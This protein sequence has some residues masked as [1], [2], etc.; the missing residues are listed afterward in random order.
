M[1]LEMQ[2]TTDA[3]D[4]PAAADVTHWAEAALTAAGRRTDLAMTV[5][6]IDEDESRSLNE[7]YRGKAGPTNV[8]A[9]QGFESPAA[10]KGHENELGD[11]AIC[12]PLVR[13]EAGEQGKDFL[14]HMAHLVIHGTL[15]LAGYGHD[16]ESEAKEM[17]TLEIDVLS[18]FGFSD[19]Y[20]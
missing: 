5:R 9:F 14:A 12:L 8:L 16:C 10:A 4:L 17:E 6:L 20:I 15:H 13:I 1:V 2:N 18:Q 19:P 3:K 7:L 11:L